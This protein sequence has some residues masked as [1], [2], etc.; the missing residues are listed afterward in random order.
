M[1]S[2]ALGSVVSAADAKSFKAVGK[3]TKVSSTEITVRTT[4]Q[5]I[6]ISHDAKTKV[7]GGEL[8]GGGVATVTYTKVAGKPYA[9][10]VAMRKADR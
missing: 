4:T 2:M 8:K 3:L 9:T 10:E 6:E 1:A 7:T 5:D